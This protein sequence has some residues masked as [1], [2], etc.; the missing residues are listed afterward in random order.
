MKRLASTLLILNLLWLTPVM[1]GQ[2]DVTLGFKAGLNL[3]NMG[4]SDT[5]G[6]DSKTGFVAGGVLN[7]DF[8]AVFA[9][10]TEVLYTQK[11]L[12]E[13]AS[14]I[15]AKLNLNYI[16]V[17]VLGKI[18]IGAKPDSKAIPHLLFGPAFAFEVG[19]SESAD[20]GGVSASIDCDDSSIPPD[21]RIKTKSFD[22][23]AVFGAGVDILAG[24]KGNVT[25]DARYT[26]GLSSV[27]ESVGFI[28]DVDIK[29]Q[30]ISIMA[31]YTI[32]IGQA[33][34]SGE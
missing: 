22:V 1:A 31:G 34:P 10:Q 5:E 3:A 17:P 9:L 26:F 14:G 23:G 16:E 21:A 29:N 28:E 32:R 24:A 25:L 33:A 4:G 6:T 15:T 19:C 2:G 12:Q 20:D 7:Y 30:A 13:S 27:I 18:L 11:G 8:S